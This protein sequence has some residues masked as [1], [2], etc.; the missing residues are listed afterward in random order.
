[1]Q[2]KKTHSLFIMFA[3]IFSIGFFGS[4]QNVNAQQSKIKEKEKEKHHSDKK[5][6]DNDDLSPAE[7]AKLAKKAKITKEQA[8]AT[9]LQRVPG[10]VVETEIEMEKGK[11]M[12]SFDIKADDGKIYDIE[13]DANTGEILKAVVDDEEDSNDDGSDNANASNHRTAAAGVSNAG[14]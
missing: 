7:Q 4:V 1:M 8:Q 2:L 11:L 10:K 14:L 3:L 9:A 12:W 13:I 5:D 6:D